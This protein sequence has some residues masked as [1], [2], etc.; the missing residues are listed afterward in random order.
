MQAMFDRGDHPARGRRGG[1]DGA[2]TTIA[3]DDGVAMRLKGKQFVP[4]GARVQM[5]F[6]GGAGYGPPSERPVD[7]VRHDL[8]QGYITA[9]TAKEV[10]GLSEDEIDAVQA[11]V[12]SGILV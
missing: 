12:A 10:Y 8:A 1:A 7:Q 5:A 3:R 4:H 6:P 9:T 11:A 2:P